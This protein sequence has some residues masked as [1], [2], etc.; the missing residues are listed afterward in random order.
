MANTGISR[1][2]ATKL[3]DLYHSVV[4]TGYNFI[5]DEFIV[6]CM[7]D[8]ELNKAIEESSGGGEHIY[9]FVRNI[10]DTITCHD[11][12]E[13]SFNEMIEW[14]SKNID[15]PMET[16]VYLS[17]A[18][19]NYHLINAVNR[20]AYERFAIK[21]DLKDVAYG[22]YTC[23]ICDFDSSKAPNDIEAFYFSTSFGL[24]L[25]CCDGCVMYMDIKQDEEYAMW[26]VDRMK[27]DDDDGEVALQDADVEV[28]KEDV[29]FSSEDED[30]DEGEGDCCDHIQCCYGKGFDYGWQKAMETITALETISAMK[31]ISTLDSSKKEKKL[32]KCDGCGLFKKLQKCGGSCDGSVKYCSLECQTKH[33]KSEHKHKCCKTH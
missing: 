9:G 28:D 15:I 3:V 1:V 2:M 27:I 29:I 31:T 14:C 32:K 7:E 33:W 8:A 25:P 24:N 17:Y 19:R 21:E 13:V 20:T 16:N 30:E 18:N 4:N 11:S 10:Y 26:G 5:F 6:R 12:I 22:S 23:A